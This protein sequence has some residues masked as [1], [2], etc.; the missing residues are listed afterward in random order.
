MRRMNKRQAII[1]VYQIATMT[2][3][4]PEIINLLCD[5]PFERCLEVL[6]VLRQSP[7]KVKAPERFIKRALEEGWTSATTPRNVKCKSAAQNE[8]RQGDQER[9]VFPF[10]NWL[11]D[12]S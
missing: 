3:P 1:M 5:Y 12:H 6:L 9:V 8:N 4:S 10:Y 11:E 7:N 2:Y